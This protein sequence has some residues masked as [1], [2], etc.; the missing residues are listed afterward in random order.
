[1]PNPFQPRARNERIVPVS[2][3][4][5]PLF[6]PMRRAWSCLISLLLRYLFTELFTKHAIP[7]PFGPE[8]K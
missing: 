3:T 7:G 5:H 2:G 6:A 1:V 8:T 4:H